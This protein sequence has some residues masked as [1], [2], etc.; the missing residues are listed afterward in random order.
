MAREFS[1]ITPMSDILNGM[2]SSIR[3]NGFTLIELLAVI[4]VIGILSA[5]L[6]PIVSGVSTGA[7]RAAC[8]H[9]LRQLHSGAMLFIQAQNQF[10]DWQ[11][12]YFNSEGTRNGILDYIGEY[13]ADHGEAKDTVATSPL[14]Q[15]EMPS[16][17][18][19]NNTY[20][21]NFRVSSHDNAIPSMLAIEKP[22]AMVHFMY[23]AARARADGTYVYTSFL[24]HMGGN[25]SIARERYYDDGYSNI[26]YM[27]GHVGRIS[28]EEGTALARHNDEQS[29]LFWRGVYN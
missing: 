14:L 2:K 29:R 22:Q 9:N 23:G 24:Y 4:A 3:S 1:L 16:F 26:V 17:S 25:G 12:W 27:D 18:T 13:S 19:I 15:Q 10:P 6:I 7:K 21:M 20:A 5:I 28:R 11:Q 8:Q